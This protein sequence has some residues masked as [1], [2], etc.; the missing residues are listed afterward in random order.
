MNDGCGY[1]QKYMEG[2]GWKLRRKRQL[3][4]LR[5]NGGIMFKVYLKEAE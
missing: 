1:S 5:R 3:G 2:F 4:R